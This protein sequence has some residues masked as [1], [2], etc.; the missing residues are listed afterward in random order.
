[1]ILGAIAAFISSSW[2]PQGGRIS[3]PKPDPCATRPRPEVSTLWYFSEKKE[4]VKGWLA[5]TLSA[6]GEE[7]WALLQEGGG[8]LTAASPAGNTAAAVCSL[9]PHT[10]SQGLGGWDLGGCL[11]TPKAQGTHRLFTGP[12]LLLSHVL[13]H[14]VAVACEQH[15]IGT[16]ACLFHF[17]WILWPD[18]TSVQA[19]TF[20]S[21]GSF[22]QA[23]PLK[24]L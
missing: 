17:C 2:F 23:E 12:A 8:R 7:P 3:R 21:I 15:R 19:V 13:A 24:I 22:S 11:W 9:P 20:A 5:L 10:Q 14:L 1:M 4:E 18:V 6:H 16:V